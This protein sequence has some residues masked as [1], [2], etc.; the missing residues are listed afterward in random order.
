MS[1]LKVG[2]RMAGQAPEKSFKW[3]DLVT[4]LA[5]MLS[6]LLNLLLVLARW[7]RL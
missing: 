2:I 6:A 3:I 5:T 4:K 7:W 1:L